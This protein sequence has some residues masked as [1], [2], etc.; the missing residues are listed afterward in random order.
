[1]LQV[2]ERSYMML[3]ISG[4]HSLIFS[5][6]LVIIFLFLYNPPFCCSNIYF[7]NLLWLCAPASINHRCVAHKKAPPV[8]RASWNCISALSGHHRR[9]STL[10]LFVIYILDFCF[11]RAIET[12]CKRPFIFYVL[13]LVFLHVGTHHKKNER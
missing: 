3:I 1:M 5:H 11:V 8:F 10:G 13:Y 2:K 9:R 6:I 12:W 4:L 7:I